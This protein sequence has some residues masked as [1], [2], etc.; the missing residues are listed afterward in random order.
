MARRTACPMRCY[1]SRARPAVVVGRGFLHSP[2][3]DRRVSRSPRRRDRSRSNPRSSVYDMN[4]ELYHSEDDD[5]SYDELNIY[6]DDYLDRRVRSRNRSNRNST[7]GQRRHRLT[8]PL[9]RL[10]DPSQ[11]VPPSTPVRDE[12]GLEDPPTLSPES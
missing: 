1:H 11:L 8:P 2:V 4:T 9:P 10:E 6:A 5:Y 3:E 7:P 12:A